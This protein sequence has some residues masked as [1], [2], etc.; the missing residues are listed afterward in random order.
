MATL[1]SGIA[2]TNGTVVTPAILNAAP[3]LTPGTIVPSDLAAG[4]IV[5]AQSVNPAAL[6]SGFT[7]PA[8]T[9][10]ATA[11][12][13]GILGAASAVLTTPYLYTGAAGTN[14]AIPG[15][16]L[17]VTTPTATAKV[18]LLGYVSASG[19]YTGLILMRNS[20]PLLVGGSAGSRTPVTLPIGDEGFNGDVT[21][22][23]PI[24]YLDSPGAAGTYTYGINVAN[25]F[26]SYQARI[27]MGNSDTTAGY[28]LR[29]TSQLIA[30]ILP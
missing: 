16:S 17:S 10:A 3:T 9:V 14:G 15:L 27:N 2:V 7:M 22:S 8:N 21:K 12:V 24:N 18:L 4:F 20:S 6:S 5:P 28:G 25:T 19:L 23:V 26:S 1:V 29:S 11:L 30:L 13:T